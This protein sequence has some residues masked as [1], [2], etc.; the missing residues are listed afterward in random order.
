MSFFARLMA[1]KLGNMM[2]LGRDL[3]PTNQLKFDY[4]VVWGH[5]TNQKSYIPT[6]T[7]PTTIKLYKIV[8]T[9]MGLPPIELEYSLIT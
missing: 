8:T 9:C 6:S 1:T 5:V 2:T 4:L 3:Q 7:K